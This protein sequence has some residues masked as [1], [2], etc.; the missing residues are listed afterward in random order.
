MPGEK[1]TEQAWKLLSRGHQDCTNIRD[2]KTQLWEARSGA[3]NSLKS[4]K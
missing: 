3:L 2:S 4:Q 1:F